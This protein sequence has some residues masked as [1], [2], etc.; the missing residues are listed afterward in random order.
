MPGKVNPTQAEA[1]TMVCAQV[2]GNDAAVGFAGSQGHFEL[3]VFK[4]VIAYNVLQ[5]MQLLGDAAAS[6][7]DNCVVGIEAD[8]ERIA[9]LMWESLML[10]TALAPTIGYDNATKV[11]KT[12]HKNGTTLKEEA[13]RLGF[14]DEETF[15]RVVQPERDAG[16]E[17]LTAPGDAMAWQGRR[18]STNIEDRRG[19]GGMGRP[20]GFGGIGAA[21]RD[22]ASA[23]SS[24]STCRRCSA[25]GG[26]QVATDSAP[27]GPNRSTTRPR[28]SSRW[29]WPRPRTSGASSSSSRTCSTPS[30]SW[31]SSPAQTSSACGFAQ[32]AM[33]PFYCPNDQT[34]YLD[35]DF[36]RVMEQ[37]LGSRGDFAKAYVI[38][39]EVGHHVQDELGAARAGQR[40]ARPGR[41]SG[42]RT[43]SRSGSSCR[44]TAMP[45]SGRSR[46]S[47]RLKLTEADIKSALDTAARIGDDALQRASQGRVVPDSFTHGSSEQRQNWFYRGFKSG[48]PDQCDTFSAR[49]SEAWASSSTCARP[50]SSVPRDEARREAPRRRP[51]AASRR[52]R[53]AAGARPSWSGGALDAHRRDDPGDLRLA[54]RPEKHSLTL[55]GHRT[56]VSLEPEFWRAFRTIAAAEG[57][58]INDLAAEIDAARAQR[59][60]GSPRRSACTCSPGTRGEAS[61]T[62]RHRVADRHDLRPLDAAHPRELPQ[63]RLHRVAVGNPVG[64]QD[65]EP[66][67]A[68]ADPDSRLVE[69]LGDAG[70]EAV[71]EQQHPPED[72]RPPQLARR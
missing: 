17:A 63:P 50:A 8:E 39:H 60:G 14:V 45:G 34:V 52:G 51:A 19:G 38:A 54:G 49:T 64:V 16:A 66:D 11:A 22:A 53:A 1:L 27:A 28:T 56:S 29:C 6:F 21:H 70:R 47:E 41:A 42:S 32:S 2:M 24:A 9:K 46:C 37:Q 43:R 71:A 4:P 20:A 5:S 72:L 7:T 3:N 30:R 40:P 26:G 12:A 61:L 18:E 23:S 62:G 13:I 10:V 69:D 55:H 25:P 31:C 68:G 33:G 48:D 36:F 59:R 58:P 35:T 65:L 67:R 44:P 57:R 15:D